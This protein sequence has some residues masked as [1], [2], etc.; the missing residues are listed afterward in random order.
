M[1]TR[2]GI[3][4]LPAGRRRVHL[5]TAFEGFVANT[6]LHRVATC[7]TAAARAAAEI[8][9]MRKRSGRPIEI[10]DTMIAGIALAPNATILTRL[11]RNVA[12]FADLDLRI[13]NPW[14]PL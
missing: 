13:V 8:K 5:A 4:A 14:E 1:E 10:R 12:H 7:D 6:I 3:V 11:T 9:A 2:F